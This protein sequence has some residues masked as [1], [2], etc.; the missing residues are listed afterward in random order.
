VQFHPEITF[1]MHHAWVAERPHELVALGIDPERLLPESGDNT[2][3]ARSLVRT[4]LDGFVGRAA[5]RRTEVA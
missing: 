5:D 3:N 2:S 1:D 4:L